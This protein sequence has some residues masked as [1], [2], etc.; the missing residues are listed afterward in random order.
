[1]VKVRDWLHSNLL[2]LN[3]KKTFYMCFHKTVASAPP[4]SL[5]TVKIHCCTN[6][7]TDCVCDQLIRSKVIKY[8]GIMIDENLSFKKHIEVISGRVRK[9]VNVMKQLRDVATVDTLKLIYYALCQSL[10]MYCVT[11]WGSAGKTFMLQVERAQRSVLKVMLKKPRM[12]PTR[13][14]YKEAAVLNVR[15]LFIFKVFN[16]FY[17]EVSSS[18]EYKTALMRRVPRLP[19]PSTVTSFAQR[20]GPY[21]KT[22][23][24]NI[25]AKNCDIKDKSSSQ[26]KQ[27]VK[28]WLLSLSYMETENILVNIS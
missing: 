15:Q 3:T 12:Y 26:L 5:P 20:F 28:K 7:N 17:K 18:V 13:D 21:I 8:L 22:R 24:F 6:R 10:L 27:S 4:P 19:V 16:K 11:C 14:L 25:V 9:I 23:L 1:M 2:T